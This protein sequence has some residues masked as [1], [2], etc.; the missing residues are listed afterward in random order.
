MKCKD[1]RLI[2]HLCEC[3]Y[4]NGVPVLLQKYAMSLNK[5]KVENVLLNEWKPRKLHEMRDVDKN[6]NISLEYVDAS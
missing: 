6:K 5:W 2:T 4:L 3:I 1:S